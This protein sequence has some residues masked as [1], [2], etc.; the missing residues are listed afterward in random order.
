[1]DE[2]KKKMTGTPVIFFFF[3]LSVG[4]PRLSPMSGGTL[5]K[6]ESR[7]DSLANVQKKNPLLQQRVLP[8]A[9]SQ[10]KHSPKRDMSY[11]CEAGV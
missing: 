8:G 6:R 7:E 1:M 11:A 2:A 10:Y 5:C 9:S 4:F 3:V